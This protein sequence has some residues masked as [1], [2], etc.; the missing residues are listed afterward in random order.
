MKMT[1]IDLNNEVIDRLIES[2]VRTYL[3]VILRA[4]GLNKT[5][6][7][8]TIDTLE[9]AEEITGLKNFMPIGISQKLGEGIYRVAISRQE[10]EK[11]LQNSNEWSA[12]YRVISILAPELFH[13]Y[14]DLNDLHGIR[15]SKGTIYPDNNSIPI[16]EKEAFK[17]SE[18]YMKKIGL[19]K[20]ESSV[21]YKTKA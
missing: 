5:L 6:I 11:T 16:Y 10:I 9:D 7:I 1:T 13:V 3:G 12:K 17:F 21:P 20:V 14:Q 8:E 19:V 4:L 2:T 18:K 15:T